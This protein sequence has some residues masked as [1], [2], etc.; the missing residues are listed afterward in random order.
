MKTIL[1]FRH[2]KSE[3]STYFCKDH[4]RSLVSEGVKEAGK[5]GIYLARRNELPDL[6]ISSTA[7]RAITTIDISI[8]SKG[9]FIS[10]YEYC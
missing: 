9:R 4:D 7:L 8:L 2:G 10:I 3:I 5:M 1:L 6:V